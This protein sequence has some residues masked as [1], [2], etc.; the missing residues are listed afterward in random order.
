MKRYSGGLLLALAAITAQAHEFWI[1]PGAYR[2]KE[3]GVLPVSLWLG[4]RFDGERFPRN[5]RLIERFEFAG[6]DSATPVVGRSGAATSIGHADHAGVHVVVYKS[7]PVYHRMSPQAFEQYL[8]AEGLQPIVAERAKRGES[9]TPGLERFLRCAK[10]LVRV[11]DAPADGFDRALGLPFEIIPVDSPFD[12][13]RRALRVRLLYA[14]RPVA[15][16]RVVAVHKQFPGR[17][18]VATSDADGIAQLSLERSGVWL[19]TSIHMRRIADDPRAEWESL[20]ASLTF[21]RPQAVIRES[22][23]PR[24]K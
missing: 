9:D 23:R 21:E 15:G 13:D 8:R 24:T 2:L 3:P 6:P 1:E 18:Q 7:R 20:W 4:E 14:G 12:G 11:G 19:L 17:H 22:N 10:S 5:E 16:A